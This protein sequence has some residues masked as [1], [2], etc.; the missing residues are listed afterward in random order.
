MILTYAPPGG[1]LGAAA[2]ALGGRR[3]RSARPRGAPP[4]QAARG[5]GRDRRGLHAARAPR[6]P[7]RRTAPSGAPDHARRLLARAP[8]HPRGDGPGSDDPQSARRHHPRDVDRDLRL[9]P[10]SL[11]RLHPDDAGRRRPGP[12][13][14]GRGRRGRPRRRVAP[15]RRPRRGPVSDRLRGVLVLPPGADVALR[16]LEPERRDG[17]GPLR[18]LRRGPVRLLAPLRRLR[19]RPGGVRPRAV[20]RRRADPDPGRPDRRAG[21]VPVRRLPDGLHGGRELRHPARATSSRSGAAAR[22]G[23]SRSGAP[24]CSAPSA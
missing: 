8:G 13:V 11:Q 9:R 3:R 17:G 2:A 22:S 15:P 5:D 20:R 10:P 14:H 4:V 24:T 6:P 21:P 12:R 1:K 18:V 7:R 16:Q 23:S 19:G